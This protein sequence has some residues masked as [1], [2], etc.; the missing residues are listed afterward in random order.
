MSLA[1]VAQQMLNALAWGSM[2]GLLAVGYSLLYGV[3]GLINFAQG[4]IL[5]VGAVSAVL[6]MSFGKGPF[7]VACIAALAASIVAGVLIER[8]AFRPVRTAGG[9][10]LFIT[11]LAV[12]VLLKNVYI[13]GLTN[14]IRHFSSPA[15]LRGS[16][17]L[18]GL[19]IYNSTMIIF[20]ITIVI[21]F[22]LL[23]FINN[24][25]VGIGMRAVAYDH[26]TAQLLG[27]NTNKVI[28]LAFII[29]S[30][31]AGISGLFWGIKYGSVQPTMGLVPVV[32]AFI[33]AVLGGI[34]NVLG[35]MVGGFIIGI[36][37]VL[38]VAFLPPELVGLRPLFV[39]GVLFLLLIFK[40][41]GLF[42]AN[43]K[44]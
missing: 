3:L 32:D 22:A 37:E 28:V 34:G 8:A 40:P 26:Q 19:V 7:W 5:M 29:S 33:A 1:Y 36:G 18:G 31:L 44:S 16:N 21:T 9:V 12:S 43:V 35:A 30:A 23:Y 10:T 17:E 38:F 11:S 41:S 24:T 20:A 27:V 15:F 4:E 6:V 13:M 2:L 42:P 25:K 14:K 39:W